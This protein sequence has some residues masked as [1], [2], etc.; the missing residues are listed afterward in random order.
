MHN[1]KSVFQNGNKTNNRKAFKSNKYAVIHIMTETLLSKQ[2]DV[3]TQ[4]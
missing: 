2:L 3:R 4:S 1:K